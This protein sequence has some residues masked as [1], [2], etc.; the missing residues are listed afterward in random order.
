MT[1]LGKSRQASLKWLSCLR[2]VRLKTG[3]G[4]AKQKIQ[5]EDKGRLVL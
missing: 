5:N 3:Y 1:L 2:K 4:I